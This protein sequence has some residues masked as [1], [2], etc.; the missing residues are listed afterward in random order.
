VAHHASPIQ[1]I[2]SQIASRATG[3][4][5]ATVRTSRGIH[6]D[7]SARSRVLIARL[8]HSLAVQANPRP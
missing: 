6:F 8:D 1:R 3:Y 4:A 2:E 7:A 5:I